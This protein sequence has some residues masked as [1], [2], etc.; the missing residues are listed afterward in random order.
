MIFFWIINSNLNENRFVVSG[1]SPAVVV[2]MM[3]NIQEAGLGIME[4][5]PALIIAASCI[6]N[7]V[8]ITGHSLII[9]V[10]FNSGQLWWIILQCPLQILFGIWLGIVSAVVL[11]FLQIDHLVWL[12]G[13]VFKFKYYILSYFI[14]DQV[15]HFEISLFACDFVGF[16]TWI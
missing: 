5:I 2:P 1:V 8:A 11:S 13:A 10:V 12:F 15:R 16:I 3:I 14:I 6:D 9:G 7:I 4:N